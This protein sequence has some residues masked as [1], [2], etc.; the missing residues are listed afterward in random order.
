METKAVLRYARVAPRK[1]RRVVDLI[2]GKQVGE[3]LHILKFLPQ[4]ASPIVDKLVRSAVA[5]A[6]QQKLGDVD[7]LRIT[8]ACVDHGPAFKRIKAGPMGR[9]MRR[10]KHTSHI[11]IVISGPSETQA[12]AG[13]KG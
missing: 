10:K 4:H 13:Q 6:E 9:G 2:R 11:T 5:N 7:T 8:R 3:A 1:A 12:G